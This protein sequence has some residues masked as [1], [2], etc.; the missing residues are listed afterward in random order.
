VG[1]EV[2]FEGGRSK[3][4]YVV[5]IASKLGVIRPSRARLKCCHELSRAELNRGKK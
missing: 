2:A 5:S 4:A 3:W 1:S